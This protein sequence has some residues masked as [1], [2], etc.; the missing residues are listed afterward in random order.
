MIISIKILV[1]EIVYGLCTLQTLYTK[2][3]KA[4]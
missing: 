3:M 1:Y 4:A 2:T